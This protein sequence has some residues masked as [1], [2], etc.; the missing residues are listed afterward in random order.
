MRWASLLLLASRL[1]P[2]SGLAPPSTV[3]GVPIG[4]VA[5]AASKVLRDLVIHPIDT[6]KARRQMGERGT[7][8]A[9]HA[10]DGSAALAPSESIYAHLY[11]GIGPSL[12]SGVPAGALYLYIGDVLRERGLN[13]GL[14][15]VAASFVFWTIRTPG[16]VVKT[17]MQVAGS[18]SRALSA[19]EAFAAVRDDEGLGALYSG[20]GQTLARSLPFDFLRFALFDQ[21]HHADAI[22][23]LLAGNP[24]FDTACGFAASGLAALITQPLDVAKTLAQGSKQLKGTTSAFQRLA[25]RTTAANF[26][27]LWWAGA[28]ERVVL[29]A[30]SGGIYFGAYDALKH[31]L[32]ALA[33]TGQAA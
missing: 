20:Y 28:P 21:I 33:A 6:V 13:S 3:A 24:A 7:S 11:D 32:E 19:L 1:H 16:E 10:S 15:G 14:A 29:A 25:S 26:V 2:G 22:E 5:G 8:P 9:Q 31:L 23:R 4:L 27:Q 18:A 30:L 17:R 12:V